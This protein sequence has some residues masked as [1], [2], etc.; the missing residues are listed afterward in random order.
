MLQSRGIIL[1]LILVLLLFFQILL[2][3]LNVKMSLP[4]YIA[5]SHN[6]NAALLLI[7]LVTQLYF[8][9]TT[10]KNI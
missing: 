6:G 4:I 7:C 10:K 9:H 8:I 1:S 3:V 5:V 2:G